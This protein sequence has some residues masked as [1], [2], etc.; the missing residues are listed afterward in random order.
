MACGCPVIT[1]NSSSL[2]EVVDKAGI[3]IDPKDIIAISNAMRLVL[4]DQKLRKN[5]IQRGLIQ[6]KKF[7]WGSYAKKIIKIFENI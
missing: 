2:P 1:S 7:T 3:L 4:T 6:A 5:M